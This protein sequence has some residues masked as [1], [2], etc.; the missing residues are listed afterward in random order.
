V[1]KAVQTAIQG[2]PASV[3]AGEVATRGIFD[4]ASL[5][6]EPVTI[7]PGRNFDLFDLKW[8]PAKLKVSALSA[9]ELTVQG[10]GPQRTMRLEARKPLS[11]TLREGEYR[12]TMR[13]RAGLAPETITKTIYNETEETLAFTGLLP[14]P[15]PEPPANF[16]YVKPGVFTMGSP[17]REEGRSVNEV[18]HEVRLSGFFMS[19]YEVTQKEYAALMRTNPSKYQSDNN[20]VEQVDWFDAVRFCNE[21]S[22][23]E[24]LTPAYTINGN[25]VT[26]NRAADGY[27]LPTEAEWEYAC[28]AG[29]SG[30]YSTNR[31]NF[32]KNLRQ[33]GGIKTNS[34]GSVDANPWG[35][36]DMH[37]NVWE[38]CWDWFNAYPTGSQTDPA[39]P[40]LG[41]TRVV[42]GG[43]WYTS[44]EQL[45]AAYRGADAPD[46]KDDS[47]GFR[48]VRSILSQS[49]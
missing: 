10:E 43:G 48:L 49:R 46:Y 15:K 7:E 20:P 22:R 35:L 17:S 42:R 4:A 44:T 2:G 33:R 36:Y 34:V 28:R 29:G 25:S 5:A 21:R 38:W 23:R 26:W 30:P 11:L 3:P 47:L 41:T 8:R 13:Y 31:A 40:A 9:G 12:F 1:A 6:Q 14:E 37:G 27:R 18:Q 24:G 19:K 16:V 32:N 39:G 45:R